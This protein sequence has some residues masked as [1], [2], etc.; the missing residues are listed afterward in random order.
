ME[1][2]DTGRIRIEPKEGMYLHFSVYQEGEI[3]EKDV[4]LVRDYIDQFDGKV[5]FLVTRDDLYWLSAGA[6]KIM[7]RDAGSRVKAVVYIDRTQTDKILS[8]YAESTYLSSV[9]VSSFDK[10]EKACEWISQ[11]GPLPKM[12]G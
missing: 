6:Q 3:S 10:I 7:Y 8:L 5:S 12:K 9:T 2:L 1:L 4:L 11:Y